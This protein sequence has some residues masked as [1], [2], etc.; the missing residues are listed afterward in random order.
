MVN[1]LVRAQNLEEQQKILDENSDL[2]RPELVQVLNLLV[3]DAEN[4]G[5]EGL[6]DR[7][8]TINGLIE[9]RLGS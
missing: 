7:L 2:I 6:S 9:S 8:Q 1:R 5:Q 4:R 3:E